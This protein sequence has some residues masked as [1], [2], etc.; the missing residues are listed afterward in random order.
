MDNELTLEFDVIPLLFSSVV[1]FLLIKLFFYFYF[2]FNSTN[3]ELI[4][5]PN[6]SNNVEKSKTAIQTNPSLEEA[7]P[8][9]NQ[10][11]KSNLLKSNSNRVGIR[12]I[13]QKL[14]PNGK[15]G[16]TTLRTSGEISNNQEYGYEIAY[17]KPSSKIQLEW[18]DKPKTI[19]IVIR[20]N[21]DKEI[22]NSVLEL[23]NWLIK[24]Y[25]VNLLIEE[26]ETNA[27]NE[28]YLQFREDFWKALGPLAEK[29][30]VEKLPFIDL[31]ITLG[32]DSTLLYVSHLFQQ[33]VPPIVSY[34]L[35]GSLEFLA[36]LKDIIIII[37]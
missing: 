10:I 19:L 11:D 33:S 16:E 6:N 14:Q 5:N 17:N 8:N 27:Q 31:T 30:T 34:Y 36:S 3:S 28:K 12:L 4:S 7:T 37:Y 22:L 13:D 26:E 25:G 21:E 23:I 15:K 20:I 1:S 24:T 29:F 32:G 2:S 35:G 18:V 9:L